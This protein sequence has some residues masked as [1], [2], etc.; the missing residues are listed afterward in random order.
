MTN[1]ITA[2]SDYDAFARAWHADELAQ[3]EVTLRKA[4]ERDLID[5]D[6]TRML[7]QVL[8]ELDEEEVLLRIPDWLAEEKVGYVDGATPTTFVG[9]IDRETEK[10][11][12]VVDSASARPLLKLANRIHHFKQGIEREKG[13]DKDRREWLE[14]RL[15]A[16]RREFEDRDDIPGLAE[17]WLPKS[18]LRNVVQRRN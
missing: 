15:T 3:H 13:A 2:Y 17:E 7:W 4:R 10:A 1:L 12:R 9:R 8:G 14:Q 11:I 6:S 16:K 5:E 18:Q